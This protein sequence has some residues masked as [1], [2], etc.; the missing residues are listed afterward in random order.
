[1]KTQTSFS[2]FFLLSLACLGV[3]SVE[4]V[5]YYV[6]TDGD[7]ISNNGLSTGAPFRTIQKAASLMTA[8]DT[9][10]IRGGTYRETVTPA[11]SGWSSSPITFTSYN[12]EPVLISGLDVVTN[13]WT[14]DTG[15][16]YQVA[17]ALPLGSKNQVFVD[18]VMAYEARWPDNSGS[19]TYFT[20]AHPTANGSQSGDGNTN[21][22]THTSLPFSNSSDLDGASIWITPGLQWNAYVMEV[23]G[24]NAAT[25]TVAYDAP[26]PGS[27]QWTAQTDD[28]F[29]IFGTKA[30][31]DADNEWWYDSGTGTLFLQAQGAV[32]PG[33]LAVEFKAREFGFILSNRNN[34]ILEGLDFKGCRI[35]ANLSSGIKLIGLRCEYIAHDAAFRTEGVYLRGN[36]NEVI[37]CEFAYSSDNLLNLELSSNGKVVNNHVHDGGYLFTNRI[38]KAM[39]SGHIISHN[40]ISDSPGTLVRL[41]MIGGVFQ[42]NDVFNGNWA[43]RDCG[44]V[45][46]NYTDGQNAVVQYNVF[47]DNLSLSTTQSHAIY[48]DGGVSDYIINRNIFYSNNMN[49]LK[50]NTPYN[51]LVYNNTSYNTSRYAVRYTD[52]GVPAAMAPDRTDG[53]ELVNNLMTCNNITQDP[54][55]PVERNPYSSRNLDPL[56]LDP[57]YANAAGNDFRISASSPAR[58]R[59]LVVPGLTDGFEGAAPDIGALEYGELMFDFGHDF[60]SPPDAGLLVLPDLSVF[61]NRNRVVNGS[62]EYGLNSPWVKGDAQTAVRANQISSAPDSKTLNGFYSAQL[63]PA[64]DSISQTVTGLTPN[65]RYVATVWA[66]AEPGQTAEFGVSGH[67]GSTQT[68]SSTSTAWTPLDILFETGPANSSATLT[69]KKSTTSASSYVYMDVC[70]L[71]QSPAPTLPI[72]PDLAYVGTPFVSVDNGASYAVAGAD[73]N[74]QLVDAPA[75]ANIGTDGVITWQAQASDVPGTYRFTTLVQDSSIPSLST[76]NTFVVVLGAPSIALS[77]EGF[78]AGTDNLSGEYIANPGTDTS[79]R[80]KFVAG[81]NPNIVGYSGEWAGLGGAQ[82]ELGTSPLP[83]LAYPGVATTGNAA[84]RRFTNGGSSRALDVDYTFDI[85]DNGAGQIG[86]D[87]TTLYVSFLMKLDDATSAGSLGLGQ[88]PGSDGEARVRADGTN[89]VFRA[90]FVDSATLVPVDTATHLFVIKFEFGVTDTVTFWM[91]PADLGEEANSPPTAV[92]SFNSPDGVDFSH[93]TLDRGTGGTAG[94]GVLFDELRFAPEWGG[95]LFLATSTLDPEPGLTLSPS[96]SDLNLQWHPVH[97]GWILQ[98]QQDS[99]SPGGWLDLAGSGSVNEWT[100]PAP[101]TSSTSQFFRLRSP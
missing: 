54:G 34:I 84:F 56:V 41:E 89:F 16:I 57:R 90:N 20:V 64:I 87:G 48:H 85:Y 17:N 100:V 71:K 9:C 79:S 53:T 76:S 29:F 2:H 40:T 63:G 75:G 73:V 97:T 51:H 82:Y 23:T 24:Y 10:F 43:I 66:K 18:G 68:L 26:V 50:I 60:L 47:H 12:G 4:A 42:H 6:A 65:M 32:D 58:D 3:C 98:T 93:L 94:N 52:L 59:G 91:D 39:G 5:D 35:I 19:I 101:F 27:T 31:L 69:L 92:L 33:T 36:G 44:L 83:S 74:Y 96:G 15:G 37:D 95:P 61:L 30:L 80:H 38:F 81:Q 46:N 8:G 88:S 99:L 77:Y 22:L 62:L 14:P 45:Y 21:F 86:R 11:N 13:S 1:M 67:G 55:A 7:D 72:Q 28:N 49:G 70:S 78:V 25:K